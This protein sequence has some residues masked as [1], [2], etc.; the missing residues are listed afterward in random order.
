MKAQQLEQLKAAFEQ[1]AVIEYLSDVITND[2][3]VTATPKWYPDTE[4]RIASAQPAPIDRKAV[5]KSKLATEL[6][7]G[8]ICNDSSSTLDLLETLVDWLEP[9]AL[10]KFEK[11]LAL[12]DIK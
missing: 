9:A 3:R 1:G 2:W 7:E 8:N 12:Y 11:E 5:I 6:Y 10:A 4:Y